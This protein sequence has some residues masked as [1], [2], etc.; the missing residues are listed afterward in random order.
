MKRSTVLVVARV[1]RGRGAQPW[2]TNN[3]I[4]L[5]RFSAAASSQ[6]FHSLS[7]PVTTGNRHPLNTSSRYPRQFLTNLKAK[8]RTCCFYS[9]DTTTNGDD[10]HD[11][12]DRYRSHVMTGT[13]VL[14]STW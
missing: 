11:P 13:L 12:Y 9:S 6:S 3:C 4:C 8:E 1:V 14:S 7:I 5:P 10:N 2:H